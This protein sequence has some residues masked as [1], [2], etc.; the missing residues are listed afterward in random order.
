MELI[1]VEFIE[2]ETGMVGTRGRGMGEM[3]RCWS[4][5]SSFKM[6]NFLGSNVQHGHFN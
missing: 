6:N 4:Q 1:K 2:T 3:G 5:T